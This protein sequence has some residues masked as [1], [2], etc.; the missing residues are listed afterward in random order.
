MHVSPVSV[1]ATRARLLAWSSP[2]NSRVKTDGAAI[3]Q[4]VFQP[5]RQPHLRPMHGRIN[6]CYFRTDLHAVA[7]VDKHTRT[8]RQHSTKPS[9]PSKPREPSK[10][11]VARG[12]V[13]ALVHIGAGHQKLFFWTK[14]LRGFG[15]WPPSAGASWDKSHDYPALRIPITRAR[16]RGSLSK[17][18]ASC[19]V[20]APASCSTSVIVTA[21]S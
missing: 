8:V 7:P 15:G 9:R 12:H 1:S 18:L 21:R 3:W 4:L 11:C 13:F 5:V 17:R 14:I 20:I 16:L 10:P 2:A 19:S 6:V